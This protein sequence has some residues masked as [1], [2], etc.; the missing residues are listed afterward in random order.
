[1]FF[2]VPPPQS[3]H[4]QFITPKSPLY[5]KIINSLAVKYVAIIFFKLLL[6]NFK[7]LPEYW[8]RLYVATQQ[9][10]TQKRKK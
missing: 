5:E 8:L 4:S 10:Y 1:M 7:W 3:F 6:A 2:Y 9:K